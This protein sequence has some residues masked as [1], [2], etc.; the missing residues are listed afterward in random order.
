M[1]FGTKK[2]SMEQPAAWIEVARSGT[3]PSVFRSRPVMKDDFVKSA[4]RARKVHRHQ[5]LWEPLE[6]EPTFVLRSMFGAKAVYLQGQIMFCFSAGREPW[7]GMLVATDQTRHAALQAEFAELRP[8]PILPKWLYLSESSDRFETLASRLV[9]LVRARDPR[10]G[11]IPKPKR[12]SST[13]RSDSVKQSPRRS[14][15]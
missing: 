15:R 3:V 12:K 10:I 8:H 9:A 7:R 1:N 5:W 14:K 6:H 11:V 2:L 4:D 13:G